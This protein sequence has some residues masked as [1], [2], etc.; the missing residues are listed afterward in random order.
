MWW[1][2]RWTSRSRPRPSC[3]SDPPTGGPPT[4][5]P[6][7]NRKRGG[8]QV[9][10]SPDVG[11]ECS[12]TGERGGLRPSLDTRAP[13]RTGVAWG[14]L[15]PTCPKVP[16]S[17][18]LSSRAI[19]IGSGPVHSR[20]RSPTEVLER[21]CDATWSRDAVSGCGRFANPQALCTRDRHYGR[22]DRHVTGRAPGHHRVLRPVGPSVGG[23]AS[24]IAG[25]EERPRRQPDS[26]NVNFAAEH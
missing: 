16:G 25:R 7:P 22:A 6:R 18:C 13:R 23:S 9:G 1:P 5:A 15:R 26:A 3:R 2:R 21:A 14:E 10:G 19:T 12:L 20:C 24:E 8:E 4:E 17:S 11:A